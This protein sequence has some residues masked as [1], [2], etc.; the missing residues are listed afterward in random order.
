MGSTHPEELGF[1]PDANLGD[2]VVE[3][4]EGE[5]SIVVEV[6][7]SHYDSYELE[8]TQPYSREDTGDKI[9]CKGEEHLLEPIVQE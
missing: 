2:S 5:S 8:F 9:V 3:V 1:L 6:K 7:P 4:N